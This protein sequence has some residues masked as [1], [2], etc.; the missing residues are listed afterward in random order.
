MDGIRAAFIAKWGQVPVLELY[1]QMAIRQQKAGDF[2]LALWWAERGIAIYGTDCARPEAVEDLQK[3]ADYFRGK[4]DPQPRPSRPLAVRSDQAEVEVLVCGA[5]G[6]RFE[7]IRV[8]GRKPTHCPECRR[9]T[10]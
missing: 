1:R 3:R 8:R 2:K 5:C 10:A 9:P 6:R 4:L 7:R